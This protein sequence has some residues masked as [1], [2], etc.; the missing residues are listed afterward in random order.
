MV[1][2][3]NSPKKA[4]D[5]YADMASMVLRVLLKE[6]QAEWTS[7]ELSKESRTS[8]A[9]ANHVLNALEEGGVL[10]RHRR[11]GKSTSLLLDP[12]ALLK[13]WTL[14]YNFSKNII[15]PFYVKSKKDK[16]LY[17]GFAPDLKAR[18]LKHNQGLVRST[19]NLRPLE[20][21]YYEAYSTEK[22]AR[23]RER[24]LKYYGSAWRALKKRIIA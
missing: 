24:K 11:G 3:T 4:V 18:F 2:I 12:P 22:L 14:H 8:I 1:E 19:K 5:I 9:W 17:I 20:L 15:Y 6:P 10:E 21:I 7:L 23:S 13:N 16:S